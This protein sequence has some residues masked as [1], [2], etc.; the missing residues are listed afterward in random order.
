MAE[1][2]T[3]AAE[4]LVDLVVEAALEEAAPAAAGAAA[5]DGNSHASGGSSQCLTVPSEA[6]TG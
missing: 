5:A 3:L 1:A 4:A 2:V 6:V